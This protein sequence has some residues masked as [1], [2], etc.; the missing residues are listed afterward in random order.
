MLLKGYDGVDVSFFGRT[1]SLYR[2]ENIQDRVYSLDGTEYILD[3]VVF[4]N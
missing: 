4:Y 1:R 3:K 2:K